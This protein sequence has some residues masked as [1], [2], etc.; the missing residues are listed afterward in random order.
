MKRMAT[1]WALAGLWAAAAAGQQ[2]RHTPVL[3]GVGATPVS[4]QRRDDRL[5]HL[6]L[7]RQDRTLRMG[8]DQLQ[9]E[10]VSSARPAPVSSDVA[11]DGRVR[12]RELLDEDSRRG[13][14]DA[15]MSD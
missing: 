15:A 10:A 9:R 14:R 1:A 3:M 13:K 5:D 12:A 11:P 6:P 7:T 2:T 4:D 8:R